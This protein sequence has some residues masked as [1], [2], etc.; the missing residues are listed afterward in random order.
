MSIQVVDNRKEQ[1]IFKIGDVRAGVLLTGIK[2]HPDAVYIKLNKKTADEH[3]RIV[4]T[5]RHCVLL[6]VKSGKIRQIHAEV[7][8]KVI[9]GMLLIS[10]VDSINEK[11]E[12]LK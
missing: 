11:M 12:M 10:E 9:K 5:P 7:N 4:W 6:N 2:G 1:N 3:L 8:A